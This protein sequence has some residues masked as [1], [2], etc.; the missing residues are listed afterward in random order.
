MDP[1]AVRAQ[2]ERLHAENPKGG[3]VVQAD[4]HAKNEVLMQVLNAA[5]QAGIQEVAVGTDR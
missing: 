5:R 4:K 3:L 1:N 2:L